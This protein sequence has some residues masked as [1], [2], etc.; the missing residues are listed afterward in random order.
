MNAQI[1]T[2][3]MATRVGLHPF[4]A[5]INKKQFAL[6]AECAMTVQFQRGHVIVPE[7]EPANRFI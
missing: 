5:G 3:S 7:G 4:L 1:E 2:E 6:L